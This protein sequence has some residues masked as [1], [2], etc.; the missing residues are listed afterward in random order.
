MR[1]INTLTF[2]IHQFPG[3]S[4]E[5]YAILSHTWGEEE[6]TLQDMEN[7]E[8]MVTVGIKRR[9]GYD[10]IKFCCDQALNDGLDWAWV[11]TCCIDKTS[12]A[13]LSE[14]I[15]SMFR[16]YS[17]AKVC[18]AWLADVTNQ[19]DIASSRWF[20][21]GWTLQELIAPKI[22][23]FYSSN[24]TCL[25]LKSELSDV[26]Q[27][28][29]G[30]DKSVLSTGEFSRVCIAKRMSWAAKRTTTRI[31]D[32][33]YSLMG[34]LGVSMPLIYGEGKKAF[35]RLQQEILRVSDDQSLF[36]WGAPKIFPDMHNFLM[37]WIPDMYGLFADSPADFLTTHEILQACTQEDNPP[38]AI[39]GNGVRL[40]Y[41]I[42]T[43]G[44]H[45]FIVLACTTRKT[46]RA[47]IG[48]PVENWDGSFYA[49]CGPLVLIFPEDWTKAHA[50]L[51]VVKEPPVGF[52]SPR[53][54]TFQV[55][56][57]PNATRKRKQDPFL[58]DEVFCL[59]HA[60]YHPAE[61]SITLSSDHR[62][63]H[64]AL[65]FAS[66]ATLDRKRQSVHGVFPILSF[67]IILGSSRYPWAIFVPILRDAHA[68]ADFH[69]VLREITEMAKH[70]M[71]KSQLK[72]RLF[73]DDRTAFL[74]RTRSIGGLLCA[75]RISP[76]VYRNL[77]VAV[78]LDINQINLVDEAVFVLIDIYE[79]DVDHE[80]S[81]PTFVHSKYAV[82]KEKP[83]EKRAMYHPNWLTI[84]E[85][86]WFIDRIPWDHPNW[87][88]T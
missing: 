65:F 60:S 59:P 38:P 42:C 87:T 12:T 43:K 85:L 27:E 9:R 86:E 57:A 49:R 81:T 17:N 16:W 11:D 6:C 3:D 32:Q 31:E 78:D 14:A 52:V 69:E 45:Q 82:H 56:R 61:H 44:V 48:I 72:E 5:D 7:M 34:I 47:Y 71:T 55:V 28:I 24:W 51:L 74:P 64:A 15:N 39:H 84:D 70:C 4:T 80:E 10:K 2:K 20:S 30:I 79:I 88:K 22:V 25:G 37:S 53:P 26:L 23:R 76:S 35:M 75:W 83:V 40:Q 8:G 13:E 73:Q 19:G 46:P 21:R 33:S 18:Y 50:K 68:D 54:T 63:P 67:A 66:S 77:E 29:T 36:A 1:L 62:G 58:L 41:P